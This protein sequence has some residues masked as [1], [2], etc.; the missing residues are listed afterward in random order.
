MV[1]NDKKGISD[2]TRRKVL[3]AAA[4]YGYEH[5]AKQSIYSQPAIIQYIV[6]IKH[7]YVVGDTEM[8]SDDLELVEE[9]KLPYVILDSSVNRDHSDCVIINNIQGAYHATSHLIQKRASAHRAP[10][11]QNPYPQF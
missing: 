7:G 8:E 11:Q 10:G 5:V 1:Y 6:F 9:L 2:A 4:E 3:Q